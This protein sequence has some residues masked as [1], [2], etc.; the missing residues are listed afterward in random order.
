M[1]LSNHISIFLTL[2]Y[3]CRKKICTK[4]EPSNTATADAYHDYVH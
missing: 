1:E 3:I 2:N 4:K